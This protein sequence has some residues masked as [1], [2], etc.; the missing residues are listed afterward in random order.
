MSIDESQ[1]VGGFS[2]IFPYILYHLMGGAD[3]ADIHVANG[4][5]ADCADAT[6]SRSNNSEITS[7]C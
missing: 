7:S 5:P 1:W 6:L 4:F 2:P 3:T